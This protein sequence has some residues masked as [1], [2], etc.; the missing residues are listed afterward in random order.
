MKL[1]IHECSYFTNYIHIVSILLLLARRETVY[2]EYDNH[3]KHNDIQL[4]T[5][6][7]YRWS[8]KD[9]LSDAVITTLFYKHMA[10]WNMR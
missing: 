6:N 10:H 8:R 1:D 2:I 4:H 9:Y 5:Q 3:Y 7:A